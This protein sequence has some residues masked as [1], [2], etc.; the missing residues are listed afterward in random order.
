[1]MVF[2]RQ[3]GG[4]VVVAIYGAIIFSAVDQ[5]ALHAVEG[6]GGLPAE[7]RDQLATAF[8]HV[9]MTGLGGVALAFACFLAMKEK[10][11]RGGP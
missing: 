5:D 8:R 9:F 6:G 11:L 2:A 3:L 10:P 7:A 4:A 1:M